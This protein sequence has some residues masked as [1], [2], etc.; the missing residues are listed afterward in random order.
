MT[1]PALS[2][3]LSRNDLMARVEPLMGVVG[4][5]ATPST[6]HTGAGWYPDKPI[7]YL[8]DGHVAVRVQ[9][10]KAAVHVS[11]ECFEP[12]GGGWIPWGEDVT[13]QE[14]VWWYVVHRMLSNAEALAE[15][16]QESERR[17]KSARM[18]YLRELVQQQ[19]SDSPDNAT[20]ETN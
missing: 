20:D 16:K 13:D 19:L 9:Y 1:F 5:T 10:G 2:K 17:S 11:E 14:G 3:M 8:L 15:A 7:W 18:A 6:Y 12:G 4:S